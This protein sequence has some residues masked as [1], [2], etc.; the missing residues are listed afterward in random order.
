MKAISTWIG[1]L[2]CVPLFWQT[3]CRWH[4]GAETCRLWH[5]PWIR[6]CDVYFIVFYWMPLLVGMLNIAQQVSLRQSLSGSSICTFVIRTY[7][8]WCEFLIYYKFKYSVKP[9]N[10]MK[11]HNAYETN[12]MAM[13]LP[14]GWWLQFSTKS[15]ATENTNRLHSERKT[16]YFSLRV[17]QL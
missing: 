13:Y 1:V 7:I 11:F 4:F 3:P 10:S 8:V 14:W 17:L 9:C 16:L 5:V 12:L 6:F 2:E 15:G